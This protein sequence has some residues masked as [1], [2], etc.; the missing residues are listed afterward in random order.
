MHPSPIFALMLVAGCASAPEA[1]PARVA[2]PVQ[3][4]ARPVAPI[5]MPE[6]SAAMP[7]PISAPP[8]PPAYRGDWRDW[9]A[10]SGDWV[11]RRDARGSIALFGVP[12]ADAELTIR[13]DRIADQIYISRRGATPANA[14]ATIRT[15]SM[16][17]TIATQPT[18]G[19]PAYLAFALAPSDPLLDA[20]GYSRGRFIIE[21]APLP[22]LVIPAWPEILRVS[23][24]C[25]R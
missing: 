7:S 21:Q 15:S 18:G 11:Y 8:A 2:A 9:P 23:E 17:R 6:G 13:C 5:P 10:M 20:M 25:R 22:V 1:L 24:D 14:P 3:P 4:V 16:A 19:T 12:G